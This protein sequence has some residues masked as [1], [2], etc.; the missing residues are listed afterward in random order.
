MEKAQTQVAVKGEAESEF[1]DEMQS[2]LAELTWSKVEASWYK[3]GDKVPNNWPGGALEYK[4][5]NKIPIW[6]HFEVS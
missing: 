1:S 6:D 2:R 3:V 4:R 5:R